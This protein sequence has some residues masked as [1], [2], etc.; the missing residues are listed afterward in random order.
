MLTKSVTVK[1]TVPMII[2]INIPPYSNLRTVLNI[3]TVDSVT[4]QQFAHIQSLKILSAG[5][6]VDGLMNEYS[7]GFMQPSFSRTA[8]SGDS[9]FYFDSAFFD[10][11]IITNTSITSLII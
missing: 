7:K 1:Q 10:L 6:N 8:K 11:G 3:S 2:T 4:G 9:S 5:R